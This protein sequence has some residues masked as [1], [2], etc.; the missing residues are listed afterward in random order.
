MK[1][2]Q[3]QEA[4]SG[5]LGTMRCKLNQIGYMAFYSVY[6]YHDFDNDC[7]AHLDPKTRTLKIYKLEQTI[8]AT[9]NTKPLDD[10]IPDLQQAKIG[11]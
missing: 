2:K 8:V 10:Y 4:L 7:L 6:L 3:L 5:T 1:V 9:E 11:V